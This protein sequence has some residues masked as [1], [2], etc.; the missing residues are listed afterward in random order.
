MSTGP[1][2]TYE[3]DIEAEDLRTVW[4]AFREG[5]VDAA[6][7]ALEV[8]EG[9]SG[10][11][12]DVASGVAFVQG[13]DDPDQ[14]LYR[15]FLEDPSNSS[16]W[17]SGIQT[18]DASDPRLDQIVAQVYD[19]FVDSSGNYSWVLQVITGTPTTGA[20]LSNRDGAATLPD[21]A[22]LLADVLVPATATDIDPSDIADRR[23]DARLLVTRPAA[24]ETGLRIVRGVIDTAS[25]GT[26]LEGE[27]FSIVRNG[28]G[29]LTVTI[30]DAFADVPAVSL[31]G[32]KHSTRFAT[33]PTASGFQVQIANE[34]AGTLAAADG[35][36]HFIAIGPA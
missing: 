9:A 8:T 18:A 20:T 32:D 34:S 25:S 4:E 24:D 29:L 12:V 35:I 36:F 19:D 7:G 2:F 10:L 17:L 21:T 16:S 30:T 1:L 6:A 14:G 3:T 31:G 11:S 33:V 28:T 5:V 22:L 15:I 13:D 26:I 27:G 23:D